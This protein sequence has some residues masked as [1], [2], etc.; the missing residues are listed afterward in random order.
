[1]Q[2]IISYYFLYKT[3]LEQNIPKKNMRKVALE[4]LLV[5]DIVKERKKIF[6]EK[7]I[8]FVRTN[9]NWAASRIQKFFR[10]RKQLTAAKRR[11]HQRRKRY[12]YHI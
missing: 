7:K 9:E 2:R 10:S 12:L 4:N 6:Q 3:F 1:M 11:M 5:N 8:D